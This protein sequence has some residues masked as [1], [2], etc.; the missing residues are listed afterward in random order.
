MRSDHSCDITRRRLIAAGGLG[1]L[2]LIS[3]RAALAADYPGGPVKMLI[4]FPPGG[5]VDT[6]GRV[7]G[8][9]LGTAMN[10]QVIIENKGGAGATIGANMVAQSAPNGYTILLNAANQIIT[11]LIAMTTPY[12][13]VKDFTS[14]C[15]IGYVP[16]LVVVRSEFPAKT[17][18]EF[19]AMVRAKPGAYT[20]ATSSLGT[21]GHLAEELINQQAGLNMP[22]V[23]YRGGGPA[24]TDTIA[25]HTTA[26][27]EPVPSAIQ[28]VRSGRL[29][30]LAV[31]SPKR[32]AS[33]P[34]V[35]TVAESGLPGFALPSWYA[36]WGPAKLPADITQ[37]LFDAAKR[38][39]RA[40]E[41][42]ARLDDM[43]FETI[44]GSPQELNEVMR[45]ETAKY[46]AI[47]KQANIKVE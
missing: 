3:N 20:W 44:A 45:T 21:T 19:V 1:G 43:A 5:T 36:L 11:P 23:G 7:I 29:K 4:P 18:E 38:A 17:F 47:V 12:D 46:A 10:Q 26:M 31:T 16:Q 28:H 41:T 42:K 40:P 22:V 15:Y 37:T 2:A 24:L 8:P 35:P 25:G 34:D 27:V 9:A 14:I 39:L 33:L 6:L 30:V 13:P 32:A